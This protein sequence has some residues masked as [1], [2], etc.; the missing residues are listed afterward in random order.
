M[1]LKT[2]VSNPKNAHV[3]C[4]RYD[5]NRYIVEYAGTFDVP[6]FLQGVYQSV[7]ADID[8]EFMTLPERQSLMLTAMEP[9]ECVVVALHEIDSGE[10][11]V[12]KFP[13]V[14]A[15]AS[16]QELKELG[17]KQATFHYIEPM[18]DPYIVTYV[19]PN[20]NWRVDHGTTTPNCATISVPLFSALTELK[21]F[22]TANSDTIEEIRNNP[23]IIEKLIRLYDT[24]ESTPRVNI[25]ATDSS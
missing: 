17:A 22:F 8:L 14:H 15:C 21:T 10:L 11:Y 19:A 13:L 5:T 7:L 24:A 1:S 6:D 20:P 9:S 18:N 12:L 3:L 4:K 25:D 23:D 2:Y 16:A